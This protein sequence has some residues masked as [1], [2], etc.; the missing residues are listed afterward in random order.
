MSSRQ[1]EKERRRQERV[2]REQ[3][4]ASAERRR[5]MLGLVA[6]GVLA[7]A[8]VAAIV[9]ALVAGG[10]GS[11][12]PKPGVHQGPKVPIPAQKQADL[13]KAMAAAGCRLRRFTPGPHDRDH[14]NHKVTYK[15]NPPVFGPHN[16]TPASDGD[17]VGQ[18]NVPRENLVHAMEHGRVIIWFKPSLAKRRISQLETLFA[19][20]IPG[21]PSGYKQILVQDAKIPGPVAATA[22]GQQMTCTQFSDKTFDALRA[23]R[24]QGVDKG[25]ENLP[26]PE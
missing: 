23:F 1:E 4:L 3:E 7:V 22:W 17:Y 14:V 25:P 9:V 10:G 11:S 2:A 6:G 24:A 5:R 20:P 18:G 8:A 26:F 16:P 21:Q 15:Q 13:S 19:E 12:K